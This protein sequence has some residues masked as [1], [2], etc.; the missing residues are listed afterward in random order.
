MTVKPLLNIDELKVYFR[1]GF[2]G[3]GRRKKFLRAVD[4]FSLKIPP[5]TTYGLVGESGC[6][7]STLAMAVLLLERPHAGRIELDGVDPAIANRQ[8]LWNYRR[9][10]Q[11]VFQDPFSSM[12]PRMRVRDVIGEP[13]DIHLNLS[14]QERLGRIQELL[15]D[16]GLPVEAGELFPHEFSGG[17]RQRIGLARA[18]ALSPK[19]VILDEPVSALDVSIRAQVINLLLDMQR[20]HD[21]AYLFIAHDIAV[22]SFMSERIGV[23]YLGK[24][25]EEAPSQELI[26]NPLH[27]YTKA[28][29]AAALP[30]AESEEIVLQGDVPSPLAPPR[31][32]R[33][34]PR[35]P[36][37]MARCAQEEPAT[38]EVAPNHYVSCFLHSNETSG[39]LP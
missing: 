1:S 13:L 29:I 18:L 39:S 16:V 33:F 25:V 23:M 17:Q 28:L 20:A 14:G 7:K 26:T 34:H 4:G 3:L 22:V 2:G 6:G 9:T 24:K 11:A 12:N 10:V 8:N 36:F 37:A 30:V 15:V 32:C 21:L 31:G 5:A 19:L 35:C 38:V 27:P